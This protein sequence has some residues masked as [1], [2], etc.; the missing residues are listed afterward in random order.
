MELTQ[1]NLTGDSHIKNNPMSSFT[2][3]NY[4]DL[5]SIRNFRKLEFVIKELFGI[6]ENTTEKVELTRMSFFYLG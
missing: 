6:C 2:L 1:T 4:T 5:P 3:H